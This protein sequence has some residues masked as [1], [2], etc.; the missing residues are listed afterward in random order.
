MRFQDYDLG[1]LRPGEIVEVKLSGSAA[2]VRL[3]DYSNFQ[4][5][6]AHRKYRYFGGLAKKSP[7]Y[8]PIP[9]SSHWH[10]VI[11]MAGLRGQVRSAVRLVPHTSPAPE[12]KYH[13]PGLSGLSIPVHNAVETP[14]D[15]LVNVLPDSQVE[16]DVFISHASEDKDAVARPLAEELNRCGLKVWY[17]ELTL[18]IGDSLR[19]KIDE[20]IYHSRFSVVI[21]SRAF[22]SKGWTNYEFDGI[23]TRAIANQINILPIWHNLNAED[24]TKFCPSL[25]DKVARDTG[26]YE[27]SDI[28]REIAQ[29]VKGAVKGEDL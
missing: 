27:I 8:L 17:D 1:Y 7:I 21:L 26:T 22:I 5:Y 28:A 25:A 15:K 29:A 11:D 18:R 14:L 6:K 2:N 23:I 13:D 3:M 12:M 19:R 10:V 4:N 16:F 9:R 20:G 24:V